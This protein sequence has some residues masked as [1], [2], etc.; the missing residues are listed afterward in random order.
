M[1]DI[2]QIIVSIRHDWTGRNV[3]GVRAH[4]YDGRWTCNVYLDVSDASVTRIIQWSWNR[5]NRQDR[6]IKVTIYGVEQ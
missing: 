3:V 2:E 5:R 6:P 1:T 4:R